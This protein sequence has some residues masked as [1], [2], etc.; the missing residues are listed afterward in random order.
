MTPQ[1]VTSRYTTNLLIKGKNEDFEVISL[2]HQQ[3]V[4]DDLVVG[5]YYNICIRQPLP[6]HSSQIASGVTPHQALERALTKF[7][8]TFR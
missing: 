2:E 1:Q 3:A 8:V 5:S 6:D 4:N 7:G